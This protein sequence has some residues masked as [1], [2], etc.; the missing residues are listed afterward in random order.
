MSKIKKLIENKKHFEGLTFTERMDVCRVNA[1]SIALI[2]NFKISETYTLGTKQKGSMEKVTADTLFQAASISKPVFAVA[3]MR[4]AERGILDIDADV[5][6]Y[7]VGYDVPTFDN[8][9]HKIT[10]R[11]VLSHNAG[12]NL[13]GFAGYQ[14][15]QEVPTI[16]QILIGA[17]P[18]NHEKLKLI[19]A[20]ETG[21]QYSGGGYVLAQKIVT[22]VCKA[23]FCDLMDEWVLSP[24]SM[25][26][27][28][29]AQPLSIDR[30]NE[31]A[32]GYNDHDLPL[33]GGYDIMP[34]LATAGLWS[35]PS[36]LARL[37][38]EIM[39]VLKDKS[40][41]IKKDTARLMTTKAYDDSRHGV[42]FVAKE[43]KK[44]LIFG[45]SGHND[46]FISNMAFCPDD[47]SGIA[48]MTNTN[49]GDDIVVEVT[50]AFKELYG[51]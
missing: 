37:G 27:S 42:G 9:K 6:E 44:G 5:A 26:H 13:H 3:V 32:F 24:L 18:A 40:V 47:G 33:P 19:K 41:F 46:G 28:T 45:H 49:I 25:V 30:L 35:T 51:W 12:L 1:I 22:D 8:Q 38:I 23:D 43:G 39:K 17:R 11:Q 31:I 10:L 14:Q 21:H 4:L 15:G 16:E 34:E 50:D 2:E 20:P 48:I 7:L 29:F 36:D